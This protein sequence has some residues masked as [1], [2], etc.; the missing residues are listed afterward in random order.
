MTE[1]P[2]DEW[3]NKIYCGDALELLPLLPEGSVDLILT[4]PPTGQRGEEEAGGSPP[5]IQAPRF[6]RKP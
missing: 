3:V 2:I 6:R 1:K 4:D 5:P